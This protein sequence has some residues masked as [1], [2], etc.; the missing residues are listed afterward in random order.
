[1]KVAPAC[2]GRASAAFSSSFAV[3]VSIVGNGLKPFPTGA[4]ALHLSIFE[5]P[6]KMTFSANG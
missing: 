5:Q 2:R 3:A 6:A 4:G 1:M